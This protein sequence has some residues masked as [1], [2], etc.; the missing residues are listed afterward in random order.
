MQK[1]NEARQ[2]Q[3]ETIER[4]IAALEADREALIRKT[5]KN[6]PGKQINDIVDR[7]IWIGMTTEMA[8]ASIGEP[9]K[10]NTSVYSWGKHEQWIYESMYLYFE[11]S[12]L[13][14]YHTKQ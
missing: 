10:V 1:N 13:K 11:N 4:E 9:E 12:I 6:L 5:F 8:S 2:I 3:I 14:S 7:K